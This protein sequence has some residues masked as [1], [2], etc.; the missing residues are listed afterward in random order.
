MLEH[1][2]SLP[3]YIFASLHPSAN[4]TAGRGRSSS[5]HTHQEIASRRKTCP[6]SR[7]RLV[8]ATFPPVSTATPK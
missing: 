8:L 3:E 4:N 5:K 6:S 2:A 7:I 1:R